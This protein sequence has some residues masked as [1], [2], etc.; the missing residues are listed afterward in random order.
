MSVNVS[1]VQL[2][3][4]EFTH[5]LEKLLAAPGIEPS[6]LCLEITES[7]LMEDVDYFS[8][9]LHELQAIGMRLSIDDFGT[10]IPRSPTCVDSRST[11]SRSIGPSS[12][13][14]TPTLRCHP[15]GS[16]DRD[17]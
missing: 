7:V 3:S 14:W 11:S 12:P 10:G 15:R 4:H 5:A 6:L 8:K 13:T 2:R 1:A 16:R 17:R 9:V